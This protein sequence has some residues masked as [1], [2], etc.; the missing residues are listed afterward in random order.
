ME[1]RIY[2]YFFQCLVQFYTSF[3]SKQR[4]LDLA[5]FFHREMTS[6]LYF[7]LLNKTSHS[8]P[9]MTHCDIFLKEIFSNDSQDEK[10]VYQN[11]L[12]KVFIKL[13]SLPQDLF[14]SR[15]LLDYFLLVYVWIWAFKNYY[16]YAIMCIIQYCQYCKPYLELEGTIKLVSC[17]VQKSK[18]K[19]FWYI[20]IKPLLEHT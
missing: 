20:I 10:C 18:L 4:S 16:Y 8:I 13:P 7:C 17:W 14:P 15:S 12:I 3:F 1:R 5:I 19:H 6:L 2:F 9:N 11:S